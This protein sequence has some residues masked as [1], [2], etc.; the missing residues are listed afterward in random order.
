MAV[1]DIDQLGDTICRVFLLE[2]IRIPDGSI[3]CKK[4]DIK[5]KD[6]LKLFPGIKDYYKKIE[7][8]KRRAEDT[9]EN[10]VSLFYLY[11]EFLFLL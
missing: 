11:T 1:P 4:I 5:S 9:G 3:M 6:F 10:R 7:M 8:E 2:P